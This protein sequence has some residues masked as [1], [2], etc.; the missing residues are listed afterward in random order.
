MLILGVM[1]P[2]GR[3]RRV[4]AGVRI[5]VLGRRRER[6]VRSR[7]SGDEQEGIVWMQL[8]RVLNE[9]DRPVSNEISE[10][11]GMVIVAMF[12][13]DAV[14][15]HQIIVVFGNSDEPHPIVPAGR[16]VTG[17]TGFV[18]SILIKIFAKI[19]RSI[20]GL[21][22]VGSVCTLLGNG[23]PIIGGGTVAGDRI[24]QCTVIVY[25]VAG[26]VGRTRRAADWSAHKGV[27][28]KDLL[29]IRKRDRTEG[30]GLATHAVKLSFLTL[31]LYLSLRYRCFS[32]IFMYPLLSH[33][34]SRFC[35]WFQSS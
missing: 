10:V 28:E 31:Q 11:V 6:T 2:V 15:A 4:H 17:S 7:R 30:R 26:E 23:L 18:E 21:F 3:S 35:H 22:D 8:G 27:R 20:A 13:N 24:I 33:E 32:Q 25:V 14:E 1:I 34:L 16:Y 12:F 5:G 29:Y 9:F 19:S